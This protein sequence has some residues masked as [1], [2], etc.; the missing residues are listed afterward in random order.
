M[1]NCVKVLVDVSTHA[2][3][4]KSLLVRRVVF[5]GVWFALSAHDLSAHES[6]RQVNIV[7]RLRK[8]HALLRI[9]MKLSKG[10]EERNHKQIV[11]LDGVGAQTRVDVL[12][13]V[14]RSS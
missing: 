12:F 1:L 2:F 3:L 10:F 5:K 9:S 7:K 14:K 6:R 4:V 13:G 8:K 11:V